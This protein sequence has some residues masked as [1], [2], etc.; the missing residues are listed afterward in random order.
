[1]QLERHKSWALLFSENL[2]LNLI[3]TLT[4]KVT[5]KSSAA[6]RHMRWHCMFSWQLASN[7]HVFMWLQR[8]VVW[9]WN[10]QCKLQTG[11]GPMTMY[12]IKWD[13]KIRP[14]E[15]VIQCSSNFVKLWTDD[16][17]KQSRNDFLLRCA[18]IWLS[19]NQFWF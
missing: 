17:I 1:M 12:F 14:R 10:L 18:I 4:I 3:E 16:T 19:C 11:A 9:Q 15:S 7:H 8:K 5:P 13:C 6:C 2:Y